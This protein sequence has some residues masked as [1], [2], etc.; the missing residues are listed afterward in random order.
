MIPMQ[1]AL[2]RRMM[3][4]GG[5][6]GETWYFK[7]N[8]TT[9][10]PSDLI[11][12]VGFTSNNN[13]YDEIGVEIFTHPMT[14]ITRINS[15]AYRAQSEIIVAYNLGAWED[16]VWRTIVLDEPATGSLLDWLSNA[17]TKIE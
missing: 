2:R 4:S 7:E 9:I 13:H 1:Y 10:V 6:S 16:D 17:A 11:Y 14:G 8:I 12:I 15:V 3:A 5:G